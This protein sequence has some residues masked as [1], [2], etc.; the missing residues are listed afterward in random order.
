[1][2]QLARFF[3]LPFWKKRLIVEA[4]CVLWAIRLG[5]W[6]LPFRRLTKWTSSDAE[7]ES[8]NEVDWEAVS[9]CVSAIRATSRIVPKANCLTQALAT[10]VLL[11]RAGQKPLMKIGIDRESDRDLGAHA[12]IEV[13][14]RIV[15]GKLESH[16][17]RFVPLESSDPV[18]I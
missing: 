4:F 8:G 17:R 6:I 14:G 3:L 11:R 9:N 10:R 18:T 15:I 12:W 1:M 7:I 5:L 16:Q 13:E 2:K